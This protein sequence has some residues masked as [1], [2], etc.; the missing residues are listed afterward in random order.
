M[1]KLFISALAVVFMFFFTSVVFAAYSSLYSDYQ[2]TYNPE[3]Y[4]VGEEKTFGLDISNPGS[5]FRVFIPGGA[6]SIS[7]ITYFGRDARIGVMTRFGMVPQCTY[8]TNKNEEE[9]YDLPWNDNSG[10]NLDGINGNDY[11]TRNYGGYSRILDA[12]SPQPLPSS[13][14]GWIYV[15]GLSYVGTSTIRA[16]AFYVTVDV[17]A[18]KVWYKNATW[19]GNSPVGTTGQSGGYCDPLWSTPGTKEPGA[20][21]TV[22]DEDTQDIT[23]IECLLLY[24]GKWI[25]GQ[26]VLP[27]SEPSPTAP[28]PSDCN[29]M[30]S[31]PGT[32]LYINKIEV[33]FGEGSGECPEGSLNIDG[34]R[35]K[36]SEDYLTLIDS[37]DN[38][39][40]FV[41][42]YN[43]EWILA[44]PA[45][46]IMKSVD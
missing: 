40:I 19:S 25:N 36:T 44:H 4:R 23:I 43:D 12:W 38:E 37:G 20:D 16:I 42:M 41:K 3:S 10:T 27:D 28:D 17:D 39:H 22:P 32:S 7:L 6:L 14:A 26:C 29:Y 24:Q 46:F 11:Q 33:A 21:P 9:Y 45:L 30:W 8:N 13:K 18:Y 2:T 5:T 35:Y 15:K 31:I 34:W 1:K